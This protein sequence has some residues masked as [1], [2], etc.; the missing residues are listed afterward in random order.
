[1]PADMRDVI[2]D[3]VYKLSVKDQSVLFLTADLGAFSLNKFR[4][5]LPNQFINMGIAEQNVINFAA[6]LAVAG[7]KPFIYSIIPFVTMRCLEQVKVCLADMELGVC[8]IG[9]GAGFTYGSDG[10]THH[11]IQDIGIMRSLGNVAIYNPCDE[12]S[13]VAAVRAAYTSK[14]PCYIRIENG[15]HEILYNDTKEAENGLKRVLVGCKLYI[16]ST[17]AMTHRALRAAKS[18]M[19]DDVGV[20]DVCRLDQLD[21]HTVMDMLGSVKNVLTVE[22][23]YISGGLGSLVE[24]TLSGKG[25]RIEKMAVRDVFSNGYGTREWLLEQCGISQEHILLKLKQMLADAGEDTF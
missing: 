17:G 11:A 13:A 22:E 6:G 24:E 16:I 3:E 21:A 20:I 8:I 2:F 14:Q 25:Y 9:G 15:S 23:N 5:E 7:K 12:V 1:M 19:L 10:P 18:Y 4:K